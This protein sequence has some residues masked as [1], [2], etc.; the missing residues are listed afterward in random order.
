MKRMQLLQEIR[1]MRFEKPMKAG[2]TGVLPK[3]MRRACWVYATAHFAVIWPVMKQ[4]GWT[5]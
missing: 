5:G 1:K 4:K 2:P 3:R